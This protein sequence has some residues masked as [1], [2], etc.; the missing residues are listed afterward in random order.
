MT[1]AYRHTYEGWR[2][3]PQAFWAEA[4]R[5]IDW[6]SAPQKIFDG[7]AGVYGRWFPD[8]ACNTCYNA[9][10]RHIA[11]RGGQAAFI[12]DSP[13]TGA[14]ESF[15]YAQ[16][17][18]EVATLAA[19]LTDLGV[20]K[21]DRVIVYMP[22]IPHAAF[23][24]LACARI[25]AVHSVV[26]GGFAARELA[27]RIDDAK[28]KLILAASCG[29]EPGRVIAYKPLLDQAMEMSAH[30]VGKVLI[31]Q[32]AQ[33]QAQLI[34]GRDYDWG[35][36]VAAARAQGRKADCVTLAATDP[37]YVLY[38]SGTT[39]IPKGVMRQ[40]RPSRRSQMVNEASLWHR[41][42]RGFLD[43][44]GCRLGRRP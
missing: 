3:D 35:S 30:K 4:A 20:G 22:M 36:L 1:G 34:E 15:T 33:M 6:V 10:D 23:A 38:T 18:D 13:I 32:R 40:W 21:G 41:S 26:F 17:L 11:T 28:P 2:N 14:K 5:E 29:I 44:L 19:V 25:G 39:G 16:T 9:L 37:L 31:F 42:R 27:K 8:A 43:R 12:Y 24:M 7:E